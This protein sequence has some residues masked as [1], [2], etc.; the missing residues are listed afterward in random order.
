MS[1]LPA[2]IPAAVPAAVPAAIPAAVPAA[3]PA[4]IPAA[5]PAAIPAAVHAAIPAAIRA[6]AAQFLFPVCSI[7]AVNAVARRCRLTT[8][9]S[10]LKKQSFSPG[11]HF[12]LDCARVRTSGN[13]S[14]NATVEYSRMTSP[15]RVSKQNNQGR[16]N[17]VWRWRSN[18]AQATSPWSN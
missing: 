16:A 15:S 11:M 17:Y 10:Y 7:F 13:M 6:A 4:A 5:V 14:G 3:V 12:G 8:M 2:A 9:E 1:P 18:Q